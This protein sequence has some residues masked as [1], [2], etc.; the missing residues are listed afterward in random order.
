MFGRFAHCRTSTTLGMTRNIAPLP[1][2][3]DSHTPMLRVCLFRYQAVWLP[4]SRCSPPLFHSHVR[5]N[6]TLAVRTACLASRVAC[7][8]EWSWLSHP[9]PPDRSQHGCTVGVLPG[10][11]RVLP[12]PRQY[13]IGRRAP[14]RAVLS[15]AASWCVVVRRIHGLWIMPSVRFVLCPLAPLL[16]MVTAV[17]LS[18]SRN[19]SHHSWLTTFADTTIC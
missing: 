3:S 8:R 7:V 16:D 18:I 1:C 15:C 19:T 12:M 14:T 5:V 9:R 6:S 4:P 17:A 2:C 11:T 13:G 10:P